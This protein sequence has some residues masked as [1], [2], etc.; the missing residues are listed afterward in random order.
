MPPDRRCSLSQVPRHRPQP[1][2]LGLKAPPVLNS[3]LCVKRTFSPVT[4]KPQDGAA[5]PPGA[6]K[7]IL[8]LSS[9]AASN[10][11]TSSLAFPS[12][13]LNSSPLARGLNELLLRNRKKVEQPWRFT[14][15]AVASSSDRCSETS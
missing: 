5:W 11:P 3:L 9:V 6:P 10:T 8:S 14:K 7:A 15:G 2:I 12:E 13:D 4:S 1:A